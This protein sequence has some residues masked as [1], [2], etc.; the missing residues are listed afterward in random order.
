VSSVN[1]N[2]NLKGVL[3]HRN[4]GITTQNAIGALRHFNC[5]PEPISLL[6]A[7]ETTDGAEAIMQ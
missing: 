4:L 6:D 7:V 5:H 2:V 1:V 3:F